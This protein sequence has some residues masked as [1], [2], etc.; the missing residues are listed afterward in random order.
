MPSNLTSPSESA[1]EGR[2][3]ESLRQL[4]T[5]RG[6]RRFKRR[7]KVPSLSKDADDVER[8]DALRSLLEELSSRNPLHALGDDDIQAI[9]GFFIRLYGSVPKYRHSY[10]DIC[11]IVF[12]LYDG[13]KAE[14]DDDGVPFEVTSLAENMNIIYEYMSL[15]L[16]SDSSCSDQTESVQKLCD[17]IELER[18][19]LRNFAEQSRLI[20]EYS[21]KN[22]ELENKFENDRAKLEKDFTRQVN[23]MRMES[24]GILGIFSAVVLVFNGAVGFSTSIISAV[25]TSGGVQTLVFI[26]AL[27]SFAL[28]NTTAILMAFLW[29][30]AFASKVEIG[31]WSKV[32]LVVADTILILIMIGLAA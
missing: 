4:Q 10:A 23:D 22:A 6:Y 30:M 14:L 2:I 11:D 13:G 9:A 26:A 20:N 5:A 32:C 15:K 21:K 12:K 19:R 27:I 7:L 25:G 1:Y 28:L 3:D 31:Y 29:K 8:R 16:T 18:T 24:I 17:H